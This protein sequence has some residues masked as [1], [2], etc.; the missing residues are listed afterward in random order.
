[1]DASAFIRFQLKGGE[2]KITRL[3]FLFSCMFFSVFC[4]AGNGTGV[5]H[6]VLVGRA[7]HEVYFDIEGT[8]NGFPCAGTH[9]AGF[10][11]AFSLTNHAAGR[12]MLSA[13]LTA[14]ASGKTLSVQGDGT[15]TVDSSMEDVG[16]V[17]LR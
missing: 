2:M 3:I 16:Y 13:I 7:G 1:M 14:Y 8:I 10:D 17:T 12:E 11:Y 5:V 15:C 9:P 6:Q 4:S